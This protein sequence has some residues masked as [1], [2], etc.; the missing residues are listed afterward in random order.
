MSEIQKS[1]MDAVVTLRKDLKGMSKNM[2]LFSLSKRSLYTE[3]AVGKKAVTT[4]KFKKLQDDTRN[5][6]MVYLKCILPNSSTFS[7]SISDYFEY[8]KTLDFLE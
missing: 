3:E 8:F 1:T 7:T 4:Q 6:A 2:R 5:D